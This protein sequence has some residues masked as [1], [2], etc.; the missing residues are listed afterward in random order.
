M[1]FRAVWLPVGLQKELLRDFKR[2]VA[3]EAYPQ[4]VRGLAAFQLAVCSFEG[5]GVP[6][7]ID[8]CCHWLSE[9]KRFS[10][11]PAGLIEKRFRAAFSGETVNGSISLEDVK[12]WSQNT[13]FGYNEI[14]RS[15]RYS[16]AAEGYVHR[17]SDVNRQFLKTDKF[18][19]TIA[20]NTYDYILMWHL[21]FGY[22]VSDNGGDSQDDPAASDL[23]R[24]PDI[25]EWTPWYKW[26][27]GVEDASFPR[28][29]QLQHAAVQGK[30]EVVQSIV[31]RPGANVDDCGQVPGFSALFISSMCGDIDLVHILLDHGAKIRC[32]DQGDALRGPNVLHWL[33][34]FTDCK[35]MERV[36]YR[37]LE[38]GLPID[39][40]DSD[41]RTPLHSTFIGED[42]SE[43][44]AAR[45]LLR[46]GS[47]P[48]LPD[49]LRFTALELAARDFDT[50]LLQVMV[51]FTET[52][53]SGNL[54]V[55]T[56]IKERIYATL[57][58]KPSFH[59]ISCLGENHRF[60]L[61]RVLSIVADSHTR[62]FIAEHDETHQT[63]LIR[64]VACGCADV[65]EVLMS[66]S[67]LDATDADGRTAL[68]W[69][70]ERR[71]AATAH[72]LL[73][74]GVDAQIHDNKGLTAL[75]L[76]ARYF[77]SF[78]EVLAKHIV[79]KLSTRL[80]DQVRDALSV[81]DNQGYSPFITALW[82]GTPEHISL[83]AQLQSRYGLSYDDKTLKTP[84]FPAPD[85]VTL[86]PLGV[87]ICTAAR[88]PSM[89]RAV[90]YL[91][92]LV[93][94]PDFCCTNV[95]GINA[96]HLAMINNG[97]L[98]PYIRQH[99]D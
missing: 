31:G 16:G 74:S 38:E 32:Q 78:M 40:A 50:D 45:L 29:T 43:G 20:Q 47:N 39:C 34:Q 23:P 1:E 51:S 54:M 33:S 99:D 90:E 91:L 4:H 37:A 97:E 42:R 55:L 49:N 66:E 46:F 62:N 9:A 86:S 2:V 7:S 14:Y 11:G 13:E 94:R 95:G 67:N 36:I 79:D 30:L 59:R 70:F 84:L 89:D 56:R 28:L 53:T 3:S 18:R 22:Q 96:L 5:Y 24:Q 6:A 73:D 64:A 12:A 88:F 93:P 98:V 72:L 15:V 65:A 63:M 8:Q 82:E 25:E 77:P 21:D 44:K 10:F 48:T 75:H 41:G 60:K 35:L 81:R 17:R 52:L 76:A 57:L 68:H 85:H 19:R 69:A 61:E 83:A 71:M 80:P 87:F 92:G 27:E 58:G 26:L